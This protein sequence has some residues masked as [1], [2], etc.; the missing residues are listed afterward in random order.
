MNNSNIIHPESENVEDVKKINRIG[1]KEHIKISSEE[2]RT[3]EELDEKIKENLSR[4]VSGKWQ[5]NICNKESRD[6]SHAKE[7]VEVHFEGL[8]FPCQNCERTFRSRCAF[9]KHKAQRC[10]VVI[11]GPG[12]YWGGINVHRRIVYYKSFI[13]SFVRFFIV[14]HYFTC[15][16][17]YP[18]VLLRLD[19]DRNQLWKWLGWSND[20]SRQFFIQNKQSSGKLPTAKS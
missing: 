13:I 9:R 16:Y 10:T 17:T 3:V 20:A 8:S 14:L 5:C 6:I 18:V 2:F 1:V 12:A 4:G 15:D 19:T 7:H 11:S